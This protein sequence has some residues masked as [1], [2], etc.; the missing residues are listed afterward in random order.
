LQGLNR[1]DFDFFA[2]DSE[3]Y[4]PYS[5]DQRVLVSEKNR[6]LVENV[7]LMTLESGLNYN[8]VVLN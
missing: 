5:N 1:D 8:L 6:Y 3:I 7:H 2:F 4:S